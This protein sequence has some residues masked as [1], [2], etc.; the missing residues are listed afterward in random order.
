LQLKYLTLFFAAVL[1]LGVGGCSSNS[2]SYSSD[3]SEKVSSNQEKSDVK[4]DEKLSEQE[5]SETAESQEDSQSSEQ[6]SDTNENDNQV[7]DS[8]STQKSSS[9]RHQLQVKRAA[10]K[11]KEVATNKVAVANKTQTQSFLVAKTLQQRLQKLVL[12]MKL[13]SI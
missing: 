12:E 1:F 2:T 10:I 9:H 13:S 5:D 6:V 7:A 8:Q 4:Q 3:K 11:A